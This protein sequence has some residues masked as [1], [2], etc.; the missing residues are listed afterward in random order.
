[1]SNTELGARRLVLHF[2]R[3]LVSEPIVCR[4]I[5][6]F[7]L[8]FNIMKAAVTPDQEGLMVIQ[9]S[10]TEENLDAGVRCLER[11]GVRVQP[12]ELDILWNESRC[13]DC[14]ACLLICPT[15]AL[16]RPAAEEAVR[17]EAGKCIACELCVNICPPRAME[18]RY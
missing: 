17:F 12:L 14:G 3:N 11:A 16:F 15:Q 4:T 9:F 5:K 7:E 8:D 6:E 10:G 1:M 18:V 13:T 2:A